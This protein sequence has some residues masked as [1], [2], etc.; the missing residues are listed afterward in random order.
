MATS[1]YRAPEMATSK[2]RAP[3]DAALR[4]GK[5]SIRA[6]ELPALRAYVI[7]AVAAGDLP[8]AALEDLGHMLRRRDVNVVEPRIVVAA[9]EEVLAYDD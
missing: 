8:A 3:F 2:Y 9:G 7:K 5:M 1:K 4:G 6:D